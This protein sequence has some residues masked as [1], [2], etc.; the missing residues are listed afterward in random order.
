[1]IE[2]YK[3]QRAAIN[4]IEEQ[5]KQS[6]TDWRHLAEEGLTVLA[7]IMFRKRHGCGLKEAHE[8]VNSFLS[9]K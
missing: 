7:I 1:M 4:L 2:I 3:A 6:D 9:S 5:I 8:A